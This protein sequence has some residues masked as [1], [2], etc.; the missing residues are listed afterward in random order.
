MKIVSPRGIV[1]ALLRPFEGERPNI[2]PKNRLARAYFFGHDRAVS[3]R[4]VLVDTKLPAEPPSP[5][6]GGPSAMPK[7]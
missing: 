5:P 3:R 4:N 1:E 2:A 7:K 6:E